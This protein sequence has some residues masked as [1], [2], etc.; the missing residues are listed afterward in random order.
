MDCG[1]ARGHGRETGWLLV[2]VIIQA[3]DGGCLHW[4][5]AMRVMRSHGLLGAVLMVE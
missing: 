5:E 4:R 1:E 2:T 3:R